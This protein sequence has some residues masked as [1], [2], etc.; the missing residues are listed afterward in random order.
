[1]TALLDATWPVSRLGEA[2]E[3]A[4]RASG[5]PVRSA[6]LP[7]PPPD[8]VRPGDAL[9]SRWIEGAASTLGLEA[10][11]V[12]TSYTALEPLVRGAGPAILRVLGEEVRF[13]ALAR[14]R[15]GRVVL[16]GPD[17]RQRA[18]DPRVVG[19]A[20][21]A[22]L[23][24]PLAPPVERALAHA[25]VPERRRPEAVRAVLRERLGATTIRG[26]WLL[27][28]PPTDR[29]RRQAAQLS[30]PR[31]LLTFAAAHGVEYSLFLLSSW[32]IG[33][34]ALEGQVDHGL[35][36]AWALALVTM[37]PF[38]LLSTWAA[39]RLAADGGALV[40]QQLLSG[41]LLL[42]GDTVRS[43]GVGQLISRVID[44]EALESLALSGGLTGLVAVLELTGA[45]LV[46]AAGAGGPAHAA[47]LLAWI[48]L[49]AALAWLTYATRV[50]WTAARL[51]MT[52][53]L[54]ERMIGHRTRVVQ[55]GRAAGHAEEDRAVEAYL[56]RSAAMD[57]AHAALA[58]LIPRGWLV[59][60]LLAL[61][62]AL[63]AQQGSAAALAA[64]VG[65]VLLGFRALQMLTAGLTSLAGALIA[66]RE[67]A[68][69]R[70]STLAA[71]A[72]PPAA[73]SLIGGEPDE[74]ALIEAHDVSFRYPGRPEPVLR[75][76]S[77]RVRRGDRVLL[78]GR[79]GSGKS[80]LAAVLA[81]LRAPTQ[82]LLL[83]G[84][85]DR[86]TLGLEGWR[87]RVAAAPQFQENHVFTGTFAYNLLMGRGWP[88]RSRDLEEAE[89]VCR[90]L[91]LGPLLDQM[92][93]GLLQTVGETGW[94]LSH[95]EKSR[96]YLARALLQ[97][98]DLIILDESFAALDPETLR[99][100]LHSVI[101]RARSVIVIAHP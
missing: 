56:Q 15:G 13:L 10:E 5:L 7:T 77:L 74:P 88:P 69:L 12:V 79:S 83:L 46:L 52:H 28:L 101:E 61:G 65:G 93:G 17:H 75:G 68:P 41:A 39:G 8:L 87:R 64:G 84:G 53:D 97:G 4:A 40:K 70:R 29:L 25:G 49:A 18:V 73:F 31:R 23:E 24:A 2:I 30:L 82:G 78:E 6:P 71:E 14:P 44:A 94:Q 54:I 72:I 26:T 22:T 85:L 16:V 19:A 21:C 59:L 96:L 55:Q 36:A 20:L 45:A 27:R 33:R 42:D 91:G 99:M 98:V 63:I 1:M 62:P 76:V 32:F 50:Q 9:L 86:R 47:V 66:W 89:E 11:P 37:V 43:Q 95:G 90:A 35:L 92:P 38:R 57:R 81:G 100:A 34:A 60:G 67:L 80:T 51:T 48:T 3:A 58:V